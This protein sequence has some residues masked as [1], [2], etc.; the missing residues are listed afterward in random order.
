MANVSIELPESILLSAGLGREEL[1]AE[2]KPSCSSSSSEGGSL[3]AK[4]PSSWR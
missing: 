4:L 3:R 2:A 1:I